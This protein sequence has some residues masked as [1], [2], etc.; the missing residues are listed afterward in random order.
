[1][2]RAKDIIV[3]PI[4]AKDANKIIRQLHYSGKVVPNSQLHFGVF[5]D[6]KCGG[7]MQFG[8]STDKRRML[9]IVEGAGWNDFLELNRLAFSDW[10]PKNSESR[11]ISQAIKYIRKN[12]P[13][14]KWI[15]SFAD[16]TQ[17]GDG[18]IY[19]ASGFHLVGIKKN[20]EIL[21][22][23]DGKR[24]NVK[25]LNSPNNIGPDGQLGS[26]WAKKNGAKPLLGYQLKYI[27]FIDGRAMGMLTVPILPYSKI[28][29]VGAAMYKG[30]RPK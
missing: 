3:K 20:T 10:L 30:K 9:G 23:I 15:I 21:Q 14:I 28:V 22:T 25:T 17:C 2:G 11:A 27:Y 8:P 5:L 13:H 12:Y 18:T 26:T 1:M 19:R 7:A 16:A 24:V 29:E 4:A 6:G